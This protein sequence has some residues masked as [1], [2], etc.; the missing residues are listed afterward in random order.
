MNSDSNKY[1]SKYLKYKNKYINLKNDLEGGVS[2]V[3]PKTKKLSSER[4][5]V[6]FS[7]PAGVGKGKI[8][9]ELDKI[10]SNRVVVSVAH[11]TRKKRPNEVNGREYFF[12]TKDE[13]K[14]L[15]DSKEIFEH[16]DFFGDI[17][18]SSFTNVNDI[19]NN[20]KIALLKMGS[21]GARIIKDNIDSIQERF[22]AK[23]SFV[24]IQPASLESLEEKLRKKGTKTEEQIKWILK[25]AESEMEHSEY[26]GLYDLV[27]P[28]KSSKETAE[29]IITFLRNL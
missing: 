14:K 29:E 20:K 9:K 19:I 28:N 27:I 18:G 16:V 11:T 26:P 4:H 2:I 22:N 10:Y 6:V 21:R 1:Y 15:I 23:I 3:I 25:T 13:M 5:I 12:V 24:F 17:Y 8:I 7:G